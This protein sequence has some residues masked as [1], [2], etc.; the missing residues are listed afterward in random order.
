[1]KKTIITQFYAIIKK[2]LRTYF[3]SP[4]AYVFIVTLLGFSFWL[5]F[6]GFFLQGQLDLRPF[7]D[8]MPWLFLL[9]IPALTMRI[10][11]EESRQGTIETL[12]TSSVP[13]PLSVIAKFT[14]CL[15][16]L[17]ITI[18][19]T[20]ILPIVLSF[21]GKLDWGQT[22]VAYLG[23]MLMGS[24]YM[25]VGLVVSSL[26]SNQ[27]VSFIISALICFILYILALPIVTYSLPSMAIPVI[28]LFSLGAHYDSIIR[29]VIDSR[30]LIYYL[31]FITLTI[32][33]NIQILESR[34]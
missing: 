29:G 8:F 10:W 20:L 33:L 4:I 2:E 16:F 14:A 5:F 27:I 12:L 7:F 6:R 31:S 26:T 28:N 17:A 25:G 22:M 32:Y 34:K 24:C 30:D 11:A 1:M 18:L 15:I 9:L 19:S 13:L 21:I 3:N 23:V